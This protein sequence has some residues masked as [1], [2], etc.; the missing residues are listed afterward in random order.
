MRTCPNPTGTLP[1][2]NQKSSC[3][4]S[5]AAYAVRDAGSG[6]RYAGRSPATAAR[7]SRSEYGHPIRSPIT[8]ARIDGYT[9]SSSR[10][11]GSNPSATDPAG[12][13]SYR[14]GPSDRSAARTVFRET[15]MT[16]A[17]C[18]T[19]RPSALCSRR[20]SAQSSTEI[21]C[22]LPGSARARLSGRRVKIQMPRRGQYSRS[23]DTRRSRCP[24]THAAIR[25]GECTRSLRRM[26]STCASAI[27]G[28]QQPTRRPV[29]A[30]DAQ[31]GVAPPSMACDRSA[32]HQESLAEVLVEAASSGSAGT[33]C[34]RW[35]AICGMRAK[36]IASRAVSYGY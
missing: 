11:R 14:G 15:S 23:V 3:A 35:R 13:R 32:T 28:L 34:W 4:I 1:S 31:F 6:G 26:P 24:V 2:G 5:P 12:A 29:T 16:R 25:A 30:Q 10:I 33:S 20:I 9:A 21:T 19:G 17:I 27:P 8:L 22:F 7:S 36:Q 18:L